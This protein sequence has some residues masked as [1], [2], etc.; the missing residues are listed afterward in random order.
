MVVRGKN[1][2]NVEDGIEKLNK[3]LELEPKYQEA[4]TGMNLIYLERADVEC[5]DL[6]P[7]NLT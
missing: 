1:W 3:A 4:V 2:S 5:D 7:A 6:Q